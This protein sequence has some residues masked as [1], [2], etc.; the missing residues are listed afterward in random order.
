VA[1]AADDLIERLGAIRD[2]VSAIDLATRLRAYAPATTAADDVITM[3]SRLVGELEHDQAHDP[4][5]RAAVIAAC[6][7]YRN[8]AF[9]FRSLAGITGEPDPQMAAV[10]ASLIELGD[11]VRSMRPTP[12]P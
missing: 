11:H 4:D 2:A 7:V 8:A 1:A 9:A 5:A 12:S 3:T 10:V 6:G